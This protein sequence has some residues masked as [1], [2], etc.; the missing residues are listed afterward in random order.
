MT[1]LNMLEF[2]QFNFKGS[3]MSDGV[4]KFTKQDNSIP[5]GNKKALLDSTASYER[6]C[7]QL[8]DFEKN[9]Y[10]HIDTSENISGVD[11]DKQIRVEVVGL[12][13]LAPAKKSDK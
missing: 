2:Q 12:E 7:K 13:S 6:L 3:S 1:D 8:L 9:K 5:G 11:I 10:N 4:I